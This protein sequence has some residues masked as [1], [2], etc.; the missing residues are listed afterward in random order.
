MIVM[1]VSAVHDVV[2]VRR[3]LLVVM[4]TIQSL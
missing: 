3:V 4:E 1:V 2:A